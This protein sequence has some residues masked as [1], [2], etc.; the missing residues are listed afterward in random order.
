M[1]ILADTQILVWSLDVN[2]PLSK[3]HRDILANA[4]NKIFTSYISLME[5]VIKKAIG[6][7]PDFVPEIDEVAALWMK[8]GY[9]ILPLTDNHIF[10]Y[11]SI[12][13]LEEHRDP[14]DRFIIATAKEENFVVMTVDK[15]FQL[16]TSIIQ[17]I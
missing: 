14:F 9:E 4:G 13:L 11:K 15:K 6:K 12:P 2:S 5:L 17:V 1:N 10:T 8:N 7:L 16:Y 3:T